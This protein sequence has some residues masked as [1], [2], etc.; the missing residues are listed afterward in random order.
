MKNL[1]IF[2][3]VSIITNVVYAQYPN[4]G[5]NPNSSMQNIGVGLQ[6][7][8]YGNYASNASQGNM[9]GEAAVMNAYGNYLVSR[10][11]ANI[12]NEMAYSMY[13]NNQRLRTTTYFEKRQING[14]YR[15]IEEWQKEER[16]RLKRSGLYDKEAIEYIY[17]IRR[18]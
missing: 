2:L 17:N 15:D 18:P 11:T 5:Y 7:I 3:F 14:Y 8:L 1:I 12:N 9:Y 4:Y 10:S 16:S 6:G 13:L